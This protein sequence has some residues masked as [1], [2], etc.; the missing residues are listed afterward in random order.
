[1]Q[2]RLAQIESRLSDIE[3]RLNALEGSAPQT[4]RRAWEPPEPSLDESFV[5]N[6]ATQIGRVLLIFGG[7]YLLRAM[8]DFQFVPTPVGLSMGAAY[9]LFWL[10]MAWRKGRI[11]GQRAAAAFF[12]GTSVFLALPLLVEATTKFQLLSGGQ[13]Y[14]ALIVYSVLALSVAVVRNLRTLGWVITAGGIATAFALL[15]VAH[16]AVLVAGYLLVLGLVTLWIVYEKTWRGLQW[17]GAI[18]AYSGSI[19]IIG[20]SF[21]DQW[22]I[23]ERTPLLFCGTL[24]VSYLASFALYTHV[25]SRSIGVFEV[26]QSLF[27][28]A[29][30]VFVVTAHDGAGLVGSGAFGVL[31]GATCYALALSPESRLLRGV[32]FYYYAMLGMLLVVAGTA[33]MMPSSGAAVTWSVLAVLVAWFSGRNGWVSL[34]LQCTVLLLAA[35]IGS[36]ILSTGLKALTGDPATGWPTAEAWQAVVA[37]GTVA[38]LFIPVAQRSERWGTAAGLPQLIVLALSVWEVGGLMV[39][40]LAPALAA[41]LTAEPN[42]AMLAA[43]RTAVLSV[44]SVTLALSSR[45]RRWPEA[46]WLVYPL[47][48]LVGI[49][50]FVE[51]FPHGHAVTLFVALA[52]VGSALLLVSRLLRR[53]PAVIPDA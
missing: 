37:L 19:A 44:A 31:L 39:A 47:L 18:G 42:L 34:S 25:R 32:N 15:I 16:I 11:D 30:A 20:F 35:A 6:F 50:L 22:Q 7:A 29:S 8:T 41:V 48:I 5:S 21:S 38:C 53:Q 24:L 36:G 43:L 46:R 14:V 13:S 1:M 12:G 17:L 27:A 45:H 49:K 9:A 3:A 28:A 4:R 33:L 52:F 40:W 2:D 26:A 51:D 23:G 10:F